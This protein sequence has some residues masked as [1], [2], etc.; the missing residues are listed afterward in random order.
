MKK[1]KILLAEDDFATR[2]FMSKFLEKYGEVD[3][4]VGGSG[5]FSD[6]VGG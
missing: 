5:C 4:T 3:V 2:K 6:V 1:L